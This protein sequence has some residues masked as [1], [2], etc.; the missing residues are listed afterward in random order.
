[1]QFFRKLHRRTAWLALSALLAA[2]LM[3][4]LAQAL[5]RT[6]GDGAVEICTPQGMKWLAVGDLA[7]DKL[8][9]T[10]AGSLDH[11][12]FCSLGSNLPALPGSPAAW[13]PP[14]GSVDVHSERFHR[15]AR[16]PHAWRSAQPRA[17]PIVS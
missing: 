3:P 9:S 10:A 2:A 1:M 7:D 16:A 13:A 5:G 8:P 12:P 15:A 17:P 4:A 14:V 6:P 11:C